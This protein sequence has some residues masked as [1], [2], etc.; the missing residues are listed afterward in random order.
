MHHCAQ[1]DLCIFAHI[2]TCRTRTFLPL[3][4]YSL[5]HSL[6][7]LPPPVSLCPG[8]TDSQG[9]LPPLLEFS[10]EGLSQWLPSESTS[11]PHGLVSLLPVEHSESSILSP[12]IPK[13]HHSAQFLQRLLGS[14]VPSVASVYPCQLLLR[15]GPGCGTGSESECPAASGLSQS[16]GLI[17]IFTQQHTA[18][19]GQVQ[20]PLSEEGNPALMHEA[21]CT[22]IFYA[23]GVRAETVLHD[24]PPSRLPAKKRVWKLDQETRS[25]V[26]PPQE[27]APHWMCA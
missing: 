6:S 18:P 24:Q 26:E 15:K 7:C 21:P 12:P 4:L 19:R 13:A 16:H 14:R 20:S 5:T 23:P 8:P 10:L 17:A 22:S 2:Q 11:P 3:C 9:L 27:V 25:S 1:S